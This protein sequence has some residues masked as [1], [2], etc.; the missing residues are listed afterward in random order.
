M[1]YNKIYNDGKKT[2][3]TSVNA[4]FKDLL[5]FFVERTDNMF[6]IAENVYIYA[7]KRDFKLYPVGLH[8][9]LDQTANSAQNVNFQTAYLINYNFNF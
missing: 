8:R 5:D 1:E 7:L 2:I 9:C 6:S 4:F 3:S